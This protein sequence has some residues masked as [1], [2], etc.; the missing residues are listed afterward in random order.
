M[1]S[2]RWAVA[3]LALAGALPAA[4]GEPAAGTHA[5]VGARIVVAPGRSLPSGTV[6]VRDGV[7][8]AVGSNLA[9]PA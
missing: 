3:A 6:V 5:L 4:G 8:A 7:I 9:V 1:A 2:N